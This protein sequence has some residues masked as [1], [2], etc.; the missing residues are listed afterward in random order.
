MRTS[1]EAWPGTITGLRCSWT[2]PAGA[3][4]AWSAS[5]WT[6]ARCRLT[7]GSCSQPSASCCRQGC[8]GPG[9]LSRAPSPSSVFRATC[10]LVE[11]DIHICDTRLG[12]LQSWRT[13]MRYSEVRCSCSSYTNSCLAGRKLN[14]KQHQA[15][16][17]CPAC[18]LQAICLLL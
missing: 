1:G 17:C 13:S 8:Y 7:P 18:S 10:H 9:A 4:C 15:T 12:Q 6:T 3:A 11:Q 5:A 16:P 14:S 2:R